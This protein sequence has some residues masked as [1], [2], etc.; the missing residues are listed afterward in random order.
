MLDRSCFAKKP[1][2]SLLEM[3][4]GLGTAPASRPQLFY[5]RSPPDGNAV[6]CS[7]TRGKFIAFSTARRHGLPPA[8]VSRVGSC[9]PAVAQANLSQGNKRHYCSEFC[10]AKFAIFA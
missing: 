8:I 4:F 5:A 2:D 1:A 7:T 10:G 3:R 6:Q 9:H